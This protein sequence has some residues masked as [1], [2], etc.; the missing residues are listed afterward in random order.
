[1]LL[2]LASAGDSSAIEEMLRRASAK[3]GP[4][5]CRFDSPEGKAMVASWGRAADFITW[6]SPPACIAE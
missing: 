6:P 4:P 5:R 2:G 3:H 1:M